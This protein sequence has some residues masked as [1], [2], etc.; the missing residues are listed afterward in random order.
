MT[1]T[2]L[3]DKVMRVFPF[4]R[5]WML[6]LRMIPLRREWEESLLELGRMVYDLFQKEK[7]EIKEEY[8]REQCQKI[9]SLE[10]ELEDLR[11]EILLLQGRRPRTRCPSCGKYIEESSNYCPYCGTEQEK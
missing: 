5:L 11:E 3:R 4:L 9:L 10:E 1:Q 6:R 7:K 2:S 8:V